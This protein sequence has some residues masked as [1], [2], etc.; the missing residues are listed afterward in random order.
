MKQRAETLIQQFPK[1]L[2][3]NYLLH[4]PAEVGKDPN[5]RWPL[6]IFLHGA[7]E[8]GT[9]L[10]VVRRAGLPQVIE[11]R[12]A[13]PF[14]A[15]SPQC[16]AN[17]WWPDHLEALD[18]L[19]AQTVTRY[20]VDLGRISLT[21]VSIG[22]FG[23]W[24]WAALHPDRFAALAPICGGGFTFHGFPERACTLKHV[25]VWVF[26]GAKDDVV[27]ARE[28]EILVDALKQCGGNVRFTLYP[29]A[30]HDAWT[31]TYHNPELY[32]WLMAQRRSNA[33]Q[34]T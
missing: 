14:I 27:P 13:F 11:E 19:L 34:S 15:V 31:E 12:D 22:G 25:P 8:R 3:L 7:S 16:P 5:Q 32:E 21:G 24:D 10:E 33:P 6:I 2:H 28:S 9:D 26:H 18:A 23:V 4:L 1:T 29:Q 20:P 30:G 17:T